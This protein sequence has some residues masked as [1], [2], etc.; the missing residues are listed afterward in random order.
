MLYTLVMIQNK[1]NAPAPQAE[2]FSMNIAALEP[3]SSCPHPS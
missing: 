3:E 2:S 1:I